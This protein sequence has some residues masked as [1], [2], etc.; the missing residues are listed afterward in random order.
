MKRYAVKRVEAVRYPILRIVF[1]DGLSGELD[2]SDAIATGEM[3]APLKDPDYFKQVAVADGGHSFGWN[4]DEI[5]HEIDFCAD[6]ARIDIETKVVE[7]A[8]EN[9]RKRSTAAE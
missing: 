5:G 9:H 8:A 7:R 2:L 3:F 1:E 6:S 4:L